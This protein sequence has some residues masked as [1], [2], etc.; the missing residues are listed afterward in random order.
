MF[1]NINKTKAKDIK[2]LHKNLRNDEFLRIF[3]INGLNVDIRAKETFKID[4]TELSIDKLKCFT[5]D[6]I[7]Y[8]VLRL[9]G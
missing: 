8:D 1:K 2:Q 3:L 7:L 5:K 6:I 9:E 4:N